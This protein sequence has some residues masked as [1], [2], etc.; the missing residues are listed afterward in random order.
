M[1]WAHK[2]ARQLLTRTVE[3]RRL[4][5]PQA[6]I[7]VGISGGADSLCLLHLLGD[8]I[9]RH[10]KNWEILPVHIAPGFPGWKPQR[11]LRACRD[12][13]FD[14]RVLTVDVPAAIAGRTEN[15]CYT[16]SR[17]RRRTLIEHATAVDARHVALGHHVEDVNETFL[18]N[19]L[20]AASGAAFRPSQSLLRD[21]ITVI[22][23]LYYFDRELIERTLRE[24]D[25][26]I[27]HNHC[28]HER[29][30]ARAR[31]R[32]FLGQLH[33]IEPRTGANLFHGLANLKP[34]YLP[35]QKASG[36]RSRRR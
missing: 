30:G 1:G 8:H 6:R 36:G 31:V 24:A 17:L 27:A 16:C 21:Q 18:V 10:R 23:P 32:R 19:L 15:P 29:H 11:V 25:I 9:T 22:R 26:R 12:L 33:R 4:V 7:V 2:T 14:C 13:S 34:D 5:P 3:G 28:P 20:F 35:E